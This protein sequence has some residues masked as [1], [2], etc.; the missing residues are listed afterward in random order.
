MDTRTT[1]LLSILLVILPVI[2]AYVLNYP[3]FVVTSVIGLIIVLYIMFTNR[4][5]ET[6]KAKVV[7]TYFS[8]VF[9]VGVTLGIFFALYSKPRLFAETG[10]IFILPFIVQFILLLKDILPSLVTKELLYFSNGYVPFL[11]VLIIGAIIGRLFSSFYT[12][13]VLYSGTLV[14]AVL[15]FLY[16]RRSG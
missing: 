7:G 9:A 14:V 5:W 12:L 11:L 13:L 4:T 1:V 3:A 16:F 10:L 15:V 6:L 8:G 2:P